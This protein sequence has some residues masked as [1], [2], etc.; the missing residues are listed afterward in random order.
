M[1]SEDV[2]KLTFIKLSVMQFVLKA[3]VILCVASTGLACLLLPGGQTAHS[4][5]K[6]PID[7][8][9]SDSICNISKESFRADLLRMA[10]VV[11]YDKCLMNHR[12]CFEALDQTL[13]DLPPKLS[14]TFWRTDYGS[15]RRFSTNIT[16]GT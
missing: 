11:I 13:Q 14:Q 2:K 4:M 7:T 6:I 5:F 8:L 12:H 1:G 9:D 16:G 10:E 3:I 15:Q